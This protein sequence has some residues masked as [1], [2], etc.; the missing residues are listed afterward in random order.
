MSGYGWS[1]LDSYGEEV[2][3]SA[4]FEDSEAA[5]AWMGDSWRDLL[6]NGV[7]EVVL[8]DHARKRTLYRMGLSE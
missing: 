4:P 7:E 2:G 3:R 8:I 6:E 5:E 1:Y